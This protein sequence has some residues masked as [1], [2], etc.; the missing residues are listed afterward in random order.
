MRFRRAGVLM[1]LLLGMSVVAQAGEGLEALSPEAKELGPVKRVQVVWVGK[2]VENF[3]PSLMS[4]YTGQLSERGYEGGQVN[5]PPGEHVVFPGFDDV[6]DVKKWLKDGHKV[7]TAASGGKQ[8]GGLAGLAQL[9]SAAIKSTMALDAVIALEAEQVASGGKASKVKGWGK[10]LLAKKLGMKESKGEEGSHDEAY[11]VRATL[12]NK[13]GAIVWSKAD[14]VDYE[15][16]KKAEEEAQDKKLDDM[17]GK[18]EAGMK[19]MEPQ[20]EAAMKQAAEKAPQAAMPAGL[21]PE[22]QA[23]FSMAM[24]NMPPGG[25]APPAGMGMMGGGGGMMKAMAKMQNKVQIGGP[26]TWGGIVARLEFAELGSQLPSI[27]SESKA[28]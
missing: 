14:S 10:K 22:Q 18:M 12:L 4:G 23:Q 7:R 28:Q 5:T 1:S 24:K 17:Q 16:L 26:D 21:T 15:T 20:R 25:A 19:Q 13:D 6:D 27:K 8:H 9:A 11:Q 3:G 2:K